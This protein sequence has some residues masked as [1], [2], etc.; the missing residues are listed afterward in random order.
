MKITTSSLPEAATKGLTTILGDAYRLEDVSSAVD[1]TEIQ[2]GLLTSLLNPAMNTE[3]FSTDTFK[4]D[5]T[6]E[7]LALPNGK[8]YTDYGPDLEKDPSRVLRYAIPSFGL[9]SNVAPADYKGR[10][11]P[12]TTGEQ[13]MT[14]EYVVA[15]MNKKAMR[16]WAA[17]DELGIAQLLTTDTNIVR[18]GPYTEYNF[19]TDITG[20]ARAAKI[21]MDLDNTALDHTQL[22]R[23]QR[24]LLAQE[25]ERS[26]DS[27]NLI[28][29]ICGD[30]FFD[31]RYS[32]EQNTGLARPLKFGLDLASQ[33]VNEDSFGAG[34]FNYAWFDGTDGI[35][36]INYG[37]EIIA[38]TK[39]I[40][41][42]DAYMIPVGAS[43]L[44]RVGYAP[45]QTRQYVNTEALTMYAWSTVDD[46]NGVT[47]WM[48]SNKLFALINP[49]A[50]RHLT[51]T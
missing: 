48:E 51:T 8:Q 1:R 22:F 23:V 4:Y 14:E 32:I 35:R 9:R 16:A 25:L 28:V 29:C 2:P 39:L 43:K 38:G 31:L 49:R 45:A 30:T 46:R 18:G 20:G 24:R 40:G 26:M 27:T 10:R 3:T 44:F 36:Y 21:D 42:A 37:S 19:H 7:T 11:I 5:E 34:T 12:G 41:D 15:A 50:I 13:F 47:T 17:F 33:P 6:T